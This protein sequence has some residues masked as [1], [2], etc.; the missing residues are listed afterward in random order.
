MPVLTELPS[1]IETGLYQRIADIATRQPDAEAIYCNDDS[2][3]YQELIEKAVC[4]TTGLAEHGLSGKRIA[5][6][7][8]NSIELVALVLA[9]ARLGCALVP[10]NL[11]LRPNQLMAQLRATNADAVISSDTGVRMLQRLEL[12]VGAV[13]IRNLAAT[14][15]NIESP[16]SGAE[17]Y[18][19][20]DADFI[21]TLSSG[22]T[23]KPKPI[24]LSQQNKIM[25]AD[26]GAECYHVSSNDVVICAS[27]FHHSLGQR[28]CFLPLL[29]GATLVLMEHFDASDWLS[30]VEEKKVTFTIAVSS[31]LQALQSGL[32][33]E[34]RELGSL[35][36][37]V[38]SS[39][40]ID[41]NLKKTLMERLGCDFHEMYGA[42]EVATVTD[43]ALSDCPE[44]K[45]LSVGKPFEDVHV[46]IL[47]EQFKPVG[48]GSVGEIACKTPRVFGGYDNLP[49]VTEAAFSGNYFLTG[50]L[51][52][53]DSD[54]YLYFVSRKK[55]LIISGGINIVPGDVE[56]VLAQHD[57][58]DMCTVIATRDAYLGEVVTAVCATSAPIDK[59]FE[60]AL[61]LY[62]NQHLAGFQN[63]RYYV[64]LEAIPLTSS[65]KPDKV[66][67]RE[68]YSDPGHI[69]EISE[70]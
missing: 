3:S 60:T 41:A 59:Q 6:H 2:C 17:P 54:G 46:R 5:L 39:A 25:R 14:C 44:D 35:R 53:L 27:P 24:L 34:S 8:K 26:Q 12:G 32:L 37:L 68:L 15:D 42:T 49:E 63:P 66:L 51:G 9:A 36:C 45:A 23:G 22:S 57:L 61:K 48:T 67:L 69:P 47:D 62:V 43:L 10:L 64:F 18:V 52:Y 70:K 7:Y 11:A 65:G 16:V 40:Q 19:D 31:H 4:F 58:I 50:D 33:D 29:R 28:L 20:V 13:S 1:Q 38:S 21:I 56:S 55:D 30:L